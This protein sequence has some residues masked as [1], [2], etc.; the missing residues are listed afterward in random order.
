MI[1][2]PARG[3]KLTGRL[4]C[5]TD[6]DHVWQKSYDVAVNDGFFGT[7]LTKNRKGTGSVWSRDDSDLD[8]LLLGCVQLWAAP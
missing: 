5:E 8:F 7:L 2:K 1:G 4:L 3:R 6:K